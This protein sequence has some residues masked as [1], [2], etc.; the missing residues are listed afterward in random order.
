MT[1]LTFGIKTKS[2]CS[3]TPF[4]WISGTWYITCFVTN[5]EARKFSM[6]IRIFSTMT[7]VSIFKTI[8]TVTKIRAFQIANFWNHGFFV[9]E[10]FFALHNHACY[11]YVTYSTPTSFPNSYNFFVAHNIFCSRF[12]FFEPIYFQ[13][14]FHF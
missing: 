7:F 11:M 13:S 5:F 1:L 3:A 9:S 14:N 8:E 10:M 6:K 4:T 2:C 12:W